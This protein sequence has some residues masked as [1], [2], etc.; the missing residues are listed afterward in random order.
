MAKK[1]TAVKNV[2]MLKASDEFVVGK[3]N[4]GYVDSDFRD[5]FYDKSFSTSTVGKFQKL[6]KYME[7]ADEIERALNPGK[8]SLG[9]VLAFLQNPPEGTKDG[10]YNLFL[11][12]D[13]VVS[14]FWNSGYGIWYLYSCSRGK[15]WFDGNRVFSPGLGSQSLNPSEST[16]TLERAIELVKKEGYKIFKEI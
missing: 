2:P 12:G 3:Y 16:L 13:K 5:Y 4:V 7:N 15:G 9:D 10:Y 6:G 11:V 1:S 14:V 8:C